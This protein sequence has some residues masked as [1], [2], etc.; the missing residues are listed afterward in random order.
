MPRRTTG[1]RAARRLSA[2]TVAAFA[3]GVAT[4][5]PAF[6][7][8]EVSAK[9]ARALAANVTL[10]FEAESESDSAG[11]TKLE[12]F[13]PE[14][15][16]PADIT[17]ADGPKGWKLARK[18]T[19]FIVSGP[20]V[21]TGENAGFSV[22][23]KQ[24]PDAKSLAFKTLQ[25][26]SDG[27]IDRWIGLQKNSENPAPV[28]DLKAAVASA[29]PTSAS[30]T[31]VEQPSVSASAVESPATDEAAAAKDDGGSFP[32]L[33]VTLGVL[34]LALVGGGVWWWQRRGTASHS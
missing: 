34:A 25:T 5:A 23:V 22:T 10:R 33:P 1:V 21:T 32:V 2:V 27:Q 11:I 30:P 9:D 8:V 19:S 29:T 15:I 17:Y 3:V 26:Y 14:G 7:H 28:L 13:P 20:A 31:A 24:L 6:A 12:V 18:D 16:E 4:A